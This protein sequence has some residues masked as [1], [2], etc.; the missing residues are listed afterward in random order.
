MLIIEDVLDD[1]HAD[2]RGHIL[3]IAAAVFFRFVAHN[4]TPL[5]HYRDR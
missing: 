1:E 3:A 5:S 2:V 4:R